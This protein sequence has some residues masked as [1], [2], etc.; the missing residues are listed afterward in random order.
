MFLERRNHAT[1]QQE[2]GYKKA[3]ES[4]MIN[5]LHPT[6]IV[7]YATKNLQQLKSNL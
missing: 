4:Q 5:W 7:S 3:S 1:K 6:E 2:T